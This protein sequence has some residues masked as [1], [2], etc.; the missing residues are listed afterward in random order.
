M[1]TKNNLC[2]YFLCVAII[3]INIIEL[4]LELL[5][6][7]K[8][9]MDFI[10]SPTFHNNIY[11]QNTTHGI[12]YYIIFIDNNINREMRGE[13]YIL[14]AISHIVICNEINTFHHQLIIL[15]CKLYYYYYHHYP[16]KDTDFKIKGYN[17]H[18]HIHGNTCGAK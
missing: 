9:K 13:N 6:C 7:G 5:F 11:K 17:T 16:P 1:A 2:T 14:L 4:E 10:Y 8:T 12:C 18:K 15:L 3:P